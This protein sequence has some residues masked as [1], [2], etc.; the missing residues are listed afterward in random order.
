MATRPLPS[1]GSSSSVCTDPEPSVGVSP[2]DRT[3]ISCT[4]SLDNIPVDVNTNDK[5][6]AVDHKDRIVDAW[7]RD[8]EYNEV[9][10]CN[11]REVEGGTLDELHDGHHSVTSGNILT[12]KL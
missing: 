3:P 6:T 4:S 5:H 11:C 8:R 2:Q 7:D 9:E 12:S 1:I 10:G